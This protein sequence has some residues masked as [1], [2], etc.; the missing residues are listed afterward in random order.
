MPIAQKL[1]IDSSASADAMAEQ[2]FGTGITLVSASYTGA[3]SD[4]GIYTGGDATA[5]GVTTSDSG[6]ILSTGKAAD[7]TSGTGTSD[8]NLSARTSTKYNLAGDSDLDS[9]Q[10]YD[11]ALLEAEAIPQGNE[12]TMQL[13]I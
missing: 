5:P 13:V 1:P 10:T 2:M 12:L 8:T 3:G 4:S 11:A 7:V 9:M 6:V